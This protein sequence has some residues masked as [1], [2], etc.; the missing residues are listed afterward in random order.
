[1]V[2][3]SRTRVSRFGGAPRPGQPKDGASH[4]AQRVRVRGGLGPRSWWYIPESGIH[5]HFKLTRQGP[6]EPMADDTQ[7][8]KAEV[9]RAM[10]PADPEHYVCGQYQGYADVPGVVPGSATEIYAALRLEIDNWRRAD[11]PIFLR[12]GKACRTGSP[13]CGCCCAACPG[14]PFL[15]LPTRA[16]PN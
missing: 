2:R 7:D 5:H 13:R 15:S 11:V 3:M 1:M 6:A 12:A 8:K 4:H 9:F 16:G 10:P 14:W